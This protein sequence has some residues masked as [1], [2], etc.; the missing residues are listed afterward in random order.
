MGRGSNTNLTVN[1]DGTFGSGRGRDGNTVRIHGSDRGRGGFEA[2]A[3]LVVHLPA[4]VKLEGHLAAGE[5]DVRGTRSDLELS[6]IAGDLF[7][8]R[9]SGALRLNSVG[10]SK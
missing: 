6:S 2:A 1:D 3:D 5:T 8:T 10:T 7:V 9:A 4:G